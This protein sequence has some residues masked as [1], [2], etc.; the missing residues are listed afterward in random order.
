M[1]KLPF[2]NYLETKEQRKK[3]GEGS[4][5]RATEDSRI[6]KIKGAGGHK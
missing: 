3:L 1:R 2:E 6:I 4:A 5:L